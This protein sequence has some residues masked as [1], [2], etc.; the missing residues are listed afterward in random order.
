MRRK[1]KQESDDHRAVRLEKR[2]LGR[3]EQ[4][5]AEDKALDAAVMRSIMQFGA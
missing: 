3:I 5:S 2:S 4:T 1:R